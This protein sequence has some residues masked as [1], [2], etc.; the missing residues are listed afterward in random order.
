LQKINGS[1]TSGKVGLENIKS[2]YRL[3]NQ[4]EVMVIETGEIF[5]VLLPLIKSEQ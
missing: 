3:L 2:K 5:K 4:E 1:A